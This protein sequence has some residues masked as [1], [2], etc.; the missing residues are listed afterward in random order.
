MKKLIVAL[1]V[2]LLGALSWGS[3]AAESSYDILRAGTRQVERLRNANGKDFLLSNVIFP[4]Q[5]RQVNVLAYLF[6]SFLRFTDPIPSDYLEKNPGYQKAIEEMFFYV[7]QAWSDWQQAANAWLPAKYRL[8]DLKFTLKD[9]YKTDINQ[10]TRWTESTLNLAVEASAGKYGFYLSGVN[11]PIRGVGRSA[12]TTKGDGFGLI[13]FFMEQEWV[14][15]L[16][17]P[18]PAAQAA[19]AEHYKKAAA[20]QMAGELYDA[21]NAGRAT[22]S[23]EAQKYVDILSQSPADTWYRQGP[24]AQ[25]NQQ[26]MTHEMGHLFGLTHIHEDSSIMAPSVE[27]G[28]GKPKPSAQDGQRLATLVCSGITTSVPNGRCAF[29]LENAAKPNKL[30]GPFRTI[31]SVYKKYRTG[32]PF[33]P[34]R[35]CKFRPLCLKR[36]T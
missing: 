15:Y 21:A 36:W 10:Q 24:W 33:P 30:S 13:Q 19:A 3:P 18:T 31:C 12:F 23:A 32:L 25:Y 35:E 20:A 28:G 17:A 22:L 14:D 8:P 6:I 16:N 9:G 26:I 4:K 29:R 5:K 27:F 11:E 34:R 2:C 1:T 7:T